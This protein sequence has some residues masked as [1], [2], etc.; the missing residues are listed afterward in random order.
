MFKRLNVENL[1]S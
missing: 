1:R